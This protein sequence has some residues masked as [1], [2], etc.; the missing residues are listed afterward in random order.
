MRESAALANKI[1]QKHKY[2]QCQINETSYKDQGKNTNFVK[3]I[4]GK[5]KFTSKDHRFGLVGSTDYIKGSRKK[6]DLHQRMVKKI[7]CT[8]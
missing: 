4:I 7:H 6:H 5:L 1:Q 2:K 3:E 8:P